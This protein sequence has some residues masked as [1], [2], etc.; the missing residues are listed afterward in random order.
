MQRSVDGPSVSAALKYMRGLQLHVSSHGV[1]ISLPSAGAVQ[2]L[3]EKKRI[4][5]KL[6]RDEGVN[7]PVTKTRS[8]NLRAPDIVRAAVW[9]GG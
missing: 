2:M 4:R 8:L 9:R 7:Q 1:N 3:S 6:G 5:A